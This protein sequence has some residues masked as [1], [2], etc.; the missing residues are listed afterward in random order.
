MLGAGEDASNL[1]NDFVE[2][3]LGRSSAVDV[4][5]SHVVL[6]CMIIAA[7]TIGM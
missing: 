6:F 4:E 5:V 2:A 1:L 3:T 7:L